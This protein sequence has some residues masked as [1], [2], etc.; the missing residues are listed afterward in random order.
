[1]VSA[2]PSSLL[3]SNEDPRPD[4]RSALVIRNVSVH[5]H[6]TSIRLE[7]QIWDS[8]T[9]ICRS[10]FCTPHD[11]CSYVAERKPPQGSLTSSLRVFILDYF[12]KS[13]TQ[14]GHRSAGHGQGMFISQQQERMEMRAM[15]AD[16]LE[17][18]S[19]DELKSSPQ[20]TRSGPGPA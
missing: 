8:M 17:R 5:G 7:P 19:S 2:F 9:E 10:E 15:K 14:D 12:R 3:A 13:S 20:R 16:A 1:M 18:K 6:R 4:R 11:V